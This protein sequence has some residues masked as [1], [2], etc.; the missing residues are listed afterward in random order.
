MQ[1]SSTSATPSQH[2]QDGITVADLEQLVLRF[3]LEHG[4]SYRPST[5]PE[6]IYFFQ[7]YA[8]RYKSPNFAWRLQI[9]ASPGPYGGISLRG[10]VEMLFSGEWTLW[11]RALMHPSG[12]KVS[13]HPRWTT[14][15]FPTLD[16]ATVFDAAMLEAIRHTYSL[17][18]DRLAPKAAGA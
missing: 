10:Q 3:C 1:T 8:E 7:G 15:E 16:E 11:T 18:A 12:A 17:E 9:T 2:K 13:P 5:E 4:L 14:S 6:S